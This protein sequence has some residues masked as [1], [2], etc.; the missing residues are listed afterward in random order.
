MSRAM[1]PRIGLRTNLRPFIQQLWQVFL[2]GLTIGLERTVI[3]ALAERDFGL[4]RGSVT[5]L[6]AFV[7]S[8]GI[9][10]AAMNFASGR[11]SETYG[12]RPV[13]IWG[14]LAA[15]PIPLMLYWAPSWGWIVAANVLL[16][17]NQGFAWS[18]T[19]TAKLDIVRQGERGLATGLNEFA[20]YTGVALA[21]IATGYLASRFD[22]RLSLLV[23][24]LVVAV[25]AL[26]SALIWFTETLPLARAEAQA[27]AAAGGA[28]VG[29]PLTAGRAMALVTWRSLP[30]QAVAQ[31][32]SI[33]K[34]VDAAM[35]VLVPVFLT[36]QGASL[37]EIAWVSGAYGLVWG[38]GQLVTGPLSDRI[39]RKKPTVA[40]FVIC[41]GGIA[42]FPLVT[43]VAA[44]AALAA[45]TGFGMALL[46]PTLIAAMGDLAPPEWRG[47]I[48]GAYRFWRDLGYAL[49]A[50]AMGIV[51]D[52]AGNPAAGF[53][54]TAI[55]MCG[56]AM[57]LIFALPETHLTGDQAK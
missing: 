27:R 4:E 48:L 13:L 24:G 56:S 49:G 14:W 53:W 7:I 10:K 37:V 8:F 25:V 3:P 18:M 2:V 16:G 9:V 20:G 55:T 32:G 5:A 23:F 6:F 26:A 47:S 29:A 15:L 50:L 31:A 51:S 36:T 43:G 12:R 19:V 54:F 34:F 30:M 11:L 28:V 45:V 46:Y 52:L 42:A 41:A 1:E 21:G 57:W 40:G 33:E 35:W 22:P 38:T 17:V 44:W 39:G